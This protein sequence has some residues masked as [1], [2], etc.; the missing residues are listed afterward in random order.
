VITIVV[1]QFIP[2]RKWTRFLH[3]RT[4]EMIRKALLDRDNIVIIEVPY[5]VK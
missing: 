3:T 5:Q 4:A 2:R 1:P